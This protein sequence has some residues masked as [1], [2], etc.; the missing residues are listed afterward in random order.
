VYTNALKGC[1]DTKKTYGRVLRKL[2][3]NFN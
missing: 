1:L 2:R 3:K